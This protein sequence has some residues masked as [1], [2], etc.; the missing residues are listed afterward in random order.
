MKLEAELENSRKISDNLATELGDLK[1]IL[2]NEQKHGAFNIQQ[3]NKARY[4][5]LGISIS[6]RTGVP[7]SVLDD[8]LHYGRTN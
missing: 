1:G 8:F 2:E 5:L 4:E 3:R 6:R 7:A